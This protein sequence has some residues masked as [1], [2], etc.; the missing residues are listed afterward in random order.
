MLIPTTKG[1]HLVGGELNYAYLGNNNYEIRLTIYRDCFNG[2]P[3]FD[4]L[5]DLRIFDSNN[6]YLRSILMEF[7]SSDTLITTL[8][9]PCI[10][11]TTNLCYEVTTYV[12][13]V[14]LQPKTG[15]YQL[16]YQRCCRNQ[17]ILNITFPLTTGAIFFATIPD[18]SV[19]R[20]NSNPV[21]NELPPTFV[22]SEL[23]F[24]FDHSAT[25][26]DGDSLVYEL[27]APFTT[28][29]AVPLPTD[30]PPFPIITWLFPYSET[31]MLGGNEPLKIDSETGLLTARPG[32]T[33]QYVVG[34]KVSE[35]R[36][37][38]YLGATYRDYQFNVELCKKFT[39]AAIIAPN[40]SCESFT[41][42]FVNNSTGNINSFLWDFGD[43][44]NADD[45]SSQRTPTYTYPDTGTYMVSLIAYSDF[46]DKCNDTAYA[47]VVI[48]PEFEQEVSFEY[49]PC[50][51]EVE[52]IT[53]TSLDSSG[54]VS[55]LWDFGDGI[56]KSPNQN[57]VYLYPAPGTYE[58]SIISNS[59]VNRGCN[60]TS[61][62]QVEVLPKFE[63]NASLTETPCSKK[64]NFN[65]TST[66]DGLFPVKY[67]WDYGPSSN[68]F[69]SANNAS[70]PYTYADAGTY[71]PT[72][73]AVVDSP[74]C[75]DTVQLNV[76]IYPDFETNYS[77]EEVK[78][79]Y[80][81]IFSASNSLDGVVPTTYSWDFGDGSTSIAPKDTHIYSGSGVY[82]TKIVITTANGCSDSLLSAF[83][84]EPFAELFVPTAFTPNND[85]EN[86][87]LFVRGDLLEMSFQL[88][89]R[90]GEK[91]FETNDQSIGW[92]GY[93]QGKL[94]DPGVFVY[95]LSTKCSNTEEVIEK[96]NIT[97]IR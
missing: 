73:I 58:V 4:P 96:G 54:N 85:G 10:D 76:R 22:C 91:V 50:T 41:A 84:K 93:Y 30:V 7:T 69:T 87:V 70:V 45:T 64:V 62:V 72:L 26:P 27:V 14:N 80:G 79:S 67:H 90:W 12:D 83:E 75:A 1:T 38:K 20:I 36:E 43:V 16:A 17:T 42:D 8:S 3:P 66:F 56:G 47:S 74:A 89:N 23:P 48:I 31:D 2:I 13:T 60:D 46:A 21:F 88:Y 39:T 63:L 94:V 33:G 86:D 6:Q 59:P 29:G 35:Y 52:F 19:E 51:Q 57:P 24:E 77:V 37:G 53:R 11:P 5:A 25:D 68:V 97:V 92:D 78:C 82:S 49:R 15:G 95:S 65:T 28:T 55:F 40:Y 44:S 18:T 34:I 71:S 81:V 32:T 9:D 61:K